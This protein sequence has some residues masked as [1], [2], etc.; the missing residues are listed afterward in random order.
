MIT[1]AIVAWRNQF[2]E[3]KEIITAEMPY[4]EQIF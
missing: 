3:S 4:D 1:A 2:L